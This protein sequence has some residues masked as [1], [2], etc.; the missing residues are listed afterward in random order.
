MRAPPKRIQIPDLSALF[1]GCSVG[2]YAGP[3]LYSLNLGGFRVSKLSAEKR[4]G[5]RL[6]GVSLGGFKTVHHREG[7]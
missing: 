6:L 5:G 1:I 4:G 3:V 7:K 2:E